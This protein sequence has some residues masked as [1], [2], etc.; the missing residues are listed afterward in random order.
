VKKDKGREKYRSSSPTAGPLEERTDISDAA[1]TLIIGCRF[2]GFGGRGFSAASFGGKMRVS[3]PVMGWFIYDYQI[4]FA[5]K[6]FW[7]LEFIR[8]FALF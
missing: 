1:D 7:I 3:R 8:I 5:F 6:N 4:I 2:Y